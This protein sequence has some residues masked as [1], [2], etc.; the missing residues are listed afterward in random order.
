MGKYDFRPARVRQATSRLLGTPR[1]EHR[2]PWFDVVGNN[3]PSQILVR[4]QPIQHPKH[5]GRRDPRRASKQFRPLPIAYE[6]DSLRQ[7]FFR[8]HPWELARPRVMLE[9]DGRGY[10]NTER[11]SLAAPGRAVNGERQVRRLDMFYHLY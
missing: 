8:D 11:V 9:N 7:T 5:T 1:L 2:P 10:Q 4:T 6:E 3:P